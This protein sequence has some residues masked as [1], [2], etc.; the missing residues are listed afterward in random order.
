MKRLF[1]F[2]ALFAAMTC[3]T[4]TSCK[5]KTEDA[6]PV[7]ISG[8]YLCL[9]N[10]DFFEVLTFSED[11][12]LD[13]RGF[14]GNKSGEEIDVWSGVKGNYK[15]DGNTIELNFEDEDNDKGVFHLNDY[16]F[17]FM[18]DNN[19]ITS[20][21]RKLTETNN[22]NI[23]GSWTSFNMSMMCDPAEEFIIFPNGDIEPFPTEGLD[24]TVIKSIVNYV[25][26]DITFAD[27]GVFYFNHTYGEQETGTY[28]NNNDM[29][30]TLTFDI[31]GTPVNIEGS[32]TQDVN[33]NE[34]YIFFNEENC[35]KLGLVYI[36]QNLL[37]YEIEVTQEE[38]EI[39]YE[40][41][42]ESFDNFAVAVSLVRQ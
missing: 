32:L 20:V 5:K 7:K 15:I 13:S 11:G 21:Y 24:G 23:K 42:N 9:N 10:Y 39:F 17:I 1:I 34:S 31:N 35:L 33:K 25:F 41:L 6:K 26:S 40:L 30:L 27:N 19:G 36:Y 12:S 4:F 3:M 18:D 29:P 2:V 14:Y 37:G 22:K 28:V 16:E 8:S 38:M